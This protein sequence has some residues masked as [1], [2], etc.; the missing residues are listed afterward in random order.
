MTPVFADP[1][2]LLSAPSPSDGFDFNSVT[3]S[4]GL[5]GFIAVFL[6]ALVV[7]GLILSM[8]RHVRRINAG[9]AAERMAQQRAQ[10]AEREGES[11]LEHDP[12]D[13]G[14][15]RTDLAQGDEGEGPSADGR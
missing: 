11:T 1:G 3:V 8:T 7:L 14:H 12:V 6:L 4:P 10:E 13:D 15:D 2:V 5:G 9:Y